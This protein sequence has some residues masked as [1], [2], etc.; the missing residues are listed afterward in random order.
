MPTQ[1]GVELEI[2][3]VIPCLNEENTV[4][5]CI[6][7][8]QDFFRKLSLHGEIIVVDNASTDNTSAV[9]ANCG[10]TVIYESRRGYGRAIR[11]GLKNSRGKVVIIGDGDMTYDFSQAG[12]MY[13]LIRD[14]QYDMVIG[15]RYGGEID[16]R[17][18]T[19]SHRIG[20]RFLS[21]CARRR[22]RTDVYDFHC[23]LRGV[24]REATMSLSFSADGMEF[25][26]EMI[27]KAAQNHL[28]IG[29]IPVDLRKCKYDR[30]KKLRTV[31]DGFRHLLYIVRPY[32]RR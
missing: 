28:R 17:E 4:A 2:S 23:G 5:F 31:R 14:G 8:I 25:A 30:K 1:E 18:M 22:F 12:T 7:E 10:A 9:A 16:K 21:W 27:A 24:L 6:E 20:V 13:E 15:N 3:V 11:T 26:T 19:V 32:K 29:Q